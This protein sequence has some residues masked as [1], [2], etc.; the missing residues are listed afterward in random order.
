MSVLQ[1][2]PRYALCWIVFSGAREY[3]ISGNV[4]NPIDTLKETKT[5]SKQT[6]KHKL[7]M[8]NYFDLNKNLGVKKAVLKL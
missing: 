1:C 5:T 3:S 4:T 7:S 2:K 6:F 8:E